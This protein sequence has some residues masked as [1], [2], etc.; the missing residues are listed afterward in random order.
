MAEPDFIV[1]PPGLIPAAPSEAPDRSVRDAPSRVLPTFPPP[2]AVPPPAAP[3][4]PAS[5]APPTGETL[6]EAP[7]RVPQPGAWRLRGEGGLEVLVLRPMV[8]GRDP[9]ADGAHASAA[10][11]TLADPARSVSKTHALVDVVDD[12]LTVTDLHSTNGTR[13]QDSDGRSHELE[14]G[15]ATP[16]A[17]GATLLLGDLALHV[18]RAPLDTV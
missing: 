16:V 8:L 13:V 12:A 5:A 6:I 2:G 15:S 11:I 7:T 3:S 10:A 14:P 4:P 17:S 1:P 18:D 9:V